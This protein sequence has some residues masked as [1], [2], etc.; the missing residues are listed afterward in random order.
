LHEVAFNG[1]RGW[2]DF[3]LNPVRVAGALLAVVLATSAS[4]EAWVRF[5]QQGY[6]PSQPKVLIVM[7]ETDL[8]GQTW[9]LRGAAGRLREGEVPESVIGAGPNSPMPYHHLIDL[10]AVT[11]PGDHVLTVPQA[12]AVTIKVRERPYAELANLPLQQMRMMRSG[13]DTVLWRRPSHLGDARAILH[14]PEGD[15]DNG[16]WEPTADGSTVDVA[17][18]WYDAGDHIKFTLTNAYATYHLLEAYETAPEI[19]TREHSTTELVDILDEAAHGLRYLLKLWPDEDTFIVQA[20]N[21]LDHNQGWRLPADDKLDG[22]RPAFAA[23]A[24]V[25]MY[26]AVAALAKGARVMAPHDPELAAACGDMAVRLLERA[27]QPDTIPTAFERDQVNDFY[28]DDSVEDQACLAA[29]EVWAL[30]GEARFLDFAIKTRPGLAK[31]VGWADWHWLANRGLAEAGASHGAPSWWAEVFQYQ[32]RAK[33]EG[34]PWGLPTRYVWGSLTRWVGAANAE[35]A[36]TLRDEARTGG[37]EFFHPVLD[38][39]FGR[40]PWGF[41]PVRRATAEHPARTLHPDRLPVAAVSDGGVFG[42]AGRAE[43]A[44]SHAEVF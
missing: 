8:A 18:G 17:G 41:L 44:R 4:A 25:Q 20:G 9:R 32:Q 40:N 28:R 14:R 10:S 12:T 34:Q 2:V 37:P 35:R 11:T 30:T 39:V 21:A 38:Y 29:T 5:N 24:Q 1:K 43:D 19:F 13:T 33:S 7:S 27:H 15:P 6:A 16:A 22:E 3:M 42:G 31:Q 23:L 36:I 26:S